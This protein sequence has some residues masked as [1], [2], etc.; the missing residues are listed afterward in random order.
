MDSSLAS[1][2]ECLHSTHHDGNVPQSEKYISLF[3]PQLSNTYLKLLVEGQGYF[4]NVS[5]CCLWE[6]FGDELVQSL[7]GQYELSFSISP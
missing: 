1:P 7:R 2:E 4:M 5:G 3:Q 6:I